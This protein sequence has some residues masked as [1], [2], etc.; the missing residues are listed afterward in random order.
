MWKIGPA[1]VQELRPK[2]WTKNF[3]LFAGVLFSNHFREKDRLFDALT[4]FVIF[5]G[6][7]GVIYILNDLRDAPSDRQHPLK[8]KRPIASGALPVP[9]AVTL[10]VVL[11]A[12]VL[13]W[14]YYLNTR[15]GHISLFYFALMVLY[16][17]V[18]KHVVILDLMVV[19]IGFVIR[20]IAGV[21]AIERSGETIP[22]TPWFITCVLFLALFIVICKRRHELVLLSSAARHHRPVL[23]HYSPAFLDQM[24]NVATTATVMSYAL[25]VTLGV[26][27]KENLRGGMVYTLPFVVYGVF[28]YL[29]L[30]YKREEGGSPEL[31]LLQDPSLLVCVLLWLGTVTWIM[32]G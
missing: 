14:A 4:G 13:D 29:Y 8:C 5:C 10:A 11:L 2:Q 20:G 32:Y 23:E 19:A 24:V 3:L 25:Y 16:T 26:S 1:I 31:L 30:V 7:S 17:L 22:I 9:V 12:F 15:F 18:L 6:L 27:Q 21:F 28:R